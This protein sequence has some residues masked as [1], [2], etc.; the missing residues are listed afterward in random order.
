M[1]AVQ[2]TCERL[3]VALVFF[4]RAPMYT[5]PSGKID[6]ERYAVVVLVTPSHTNTHNRSTADIWFEYL[7]QMQSTATQNTYIQWDGEKREKG[8][9]SE[10][11][12][13]RPE[14]MCFTHLCI[15]HCAICTE[16]CFF[17]SDCI[18]ERFECVFD[19]VCCCCCF[20]RCRW[21]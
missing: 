16:N 19:V 12:G 11:E 14:W 21:W 17:S 10:W 2:W 3:Y 15:S 5:I 4:G 9:E 1:S 8:R 20:C 7:V 6:I 13:E 18:R